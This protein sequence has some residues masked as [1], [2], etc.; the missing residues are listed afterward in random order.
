MGGVVTLAR[1]TDNPDRPSLTDWAEEMAA[2]AR[3]ARGVAATPFCP[4]NMRVVHQGETDLGATTAVIAAALLTGKE[5]GLEPMAALRSI[6]IVNG[7]PAMYAVAARALL[8][9]RGHAIE[10]VESTN[11][12]CQMRG[13]RR[14]SDHWQ[15]PVVWDIDRAKALG[16]AQ[17]PNWR[18]QPKSM[19]IARATGECVRLT[20]PEVLL[21]LPYLA[22][23]LE[24]AGMDGVAPA[25]NTDATAPGPPPAKR[26]ARRRDRPGQATPP[27]GSP[28]PEPT[29]ASPLGDEPPLDEGT[30]LGAPEDVPRP[31][32]GQPLLSTAQSRAL[33]AGFRDLGMD[34][35]E[36]L[37]NASAWIGHDITT[38]NELTRDEATT[39][40]RH[41]NIEKARR[42]DRQNRDEGTQGEL[43]DW[44]GGEDAPTPDDD[45]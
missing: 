45:R 22:E 3:I 9:A 4:D 37:A 15:E 23:E 5:V 7:T 14:G 26:T 44:L 27:A 18:T 28:S 43:D 34:R 21:G 10:V 17:R 42:A 12:R 16:I 24:D 11:T 25:G 2:A 40:I 30:G 6:Y 8:I 38:T 31:T 32:A 33:H 35:D 41:I 20:A 36:A 39:C 29:K 13:R 1:V 19:L